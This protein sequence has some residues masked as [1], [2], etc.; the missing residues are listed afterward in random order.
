MSKDKQPVSVPD[1]RIFIPIHEGIEKRGGQNAAP[2]KPR[3]N[4][5]PPA[6]PPPKKG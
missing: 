3:P 5:P 1:P 6:Q 2:L 4:N